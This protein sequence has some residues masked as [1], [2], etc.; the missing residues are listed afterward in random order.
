MSELMSTVMVVPIEKLIVDDTYQRPLTEKKPFEK[1]LYDPNKA[2]VIYVSARD[3]GTFAVIDGQTRTYAAKYCKQ[4][5][6]LCQVHRGLTLAEES[7][8]FVAYNAN[9]VKVPLRIIHK[10]NVARGEGIAVR[11]ETHAQAYGYMLGSGS[12]KGIP[13]IGTFYEYMA[14]FGDAV[15]SQALWLCSEIDPENKLP[16]NV[17]LGLCDLFDTSPENK[18]IDFEEDMLVTLKKYSFKQLQEGIKAYLFQ[19]GMREHGRT[20]R[21]R[22]NAVGHKLF[23][24]LDAKRRGSYRLVRPK[25]Y[26][27]PHS[28]TLHTVPTE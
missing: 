21:T 20:S 5:H 25:K 19:M 26:A 8:L 13:W 27:E 6:M 4:P 2:G 1:A 11:A 22:T 17:L 16:S 12:T 3:D 15:F 24:R 23:E 18:G 28:D 14:S 7:E 10:A 9:R